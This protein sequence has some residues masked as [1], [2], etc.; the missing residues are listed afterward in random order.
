MS[1]VWFVTGSSRGLGL[2]IAR[3]LLKS[4]ESVVATA[5]NETAVTD[6]L[7]TSERLLALPLDVTEESA[8]T[9][10]ARATVERFGRIDVLV[11]NAGYGHFGPFEDASA[12]AVEDQFQMNFFGAMHVT[13][14]ILPYLRHQRSGRIFNITSI[15]GI[16]GFPMCSLYCASSSPWKDGRNRSR[17]S[18]PRSASRSPP[19]SRD[20]LEQTFCRRSLCVTPNHGTRSTAKAWPVSRHG[21]MVNITSRPVILSDWR[22]F[23]SIS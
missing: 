12:H 5:R 4:G 8:A 14:A 6:A 16:T 17:W 2:H 3:T 20:F 1:N 21:L 23:S 7:G 19:S 22:T 10:A 18:Y 15:A 9:E 13:R 11:N